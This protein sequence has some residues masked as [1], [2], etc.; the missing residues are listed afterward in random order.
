MALDLV[1]L[2][3][4]VDR[5]KKVSSDYEACEP[6]YEEGTLLLTGR[7]LVLLERESEARVELEA[8]TAEQ[9]TELFDAY[10]TLRAKVETA[11]LALLSDSAELKLGNG[12]GGE[13]RLVP[14]DRI[15]EVFLTLLGPHDVV[16]LRAEECGKEFFDYY[17]SRPAG[18]TG[19]CRATLKSKRK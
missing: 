15:K 4:L 3:K 16:A 5:W 17:C 2:K 7:A 11:R 13:T 8:S 14:R 10:M 19:E 9:I 6:K 18:H 12:L 1:E